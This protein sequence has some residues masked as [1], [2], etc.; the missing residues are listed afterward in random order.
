[1]SVKELEPF[2][3]LAVP[4]GLKPALLAASGAQL[5]AALSKLIYE[6][7]LV[8]TGPE[9]RETK[10]GP[11]AILRHMSPRESCQEQFMVPRC[12]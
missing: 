7:V 1:M 5:I 2:I 8:P 11:A 6:W 9:R 4:Q 12:C 3:K 10:T